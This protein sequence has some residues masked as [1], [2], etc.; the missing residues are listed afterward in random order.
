MGSPTWDGWAGR[1]YLQAIKKEKSPEDKEIVIDI[2][3][4][5]K[6]MLGAAIWPLAA[7]QEM[8]SGAMFAKDDEIPVSPR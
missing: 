8:S 1:S 2:P 4:A 3:L 7:F 6:C 5:I